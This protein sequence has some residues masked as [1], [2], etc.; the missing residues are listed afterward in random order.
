MLWPRLNLEVHLSELQ[1]E[2]ISPVERLSSG[3]VCV[4]G[5]DPPSTV[6]G[7]CLHLT[8]N[9]GVS[10]YIPS[11]VCTSPLTDKTQRGRGF[12]SLKGLRVC[13]GEERASSV[14]RKTERTRTVVLS[15]FLF[16]PQPQ[17]SFR[18]VSHSS[19]PKNKK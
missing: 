12:C 14:P 4:G 7:A 19:K 1:R 16:S 11:P 10:F 2:P 5:L 3:R 6:I 8:V 9:K 17:H 15:S 13:E 18:K